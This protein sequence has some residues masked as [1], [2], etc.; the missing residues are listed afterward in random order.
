MEESTSPKIRTNLYFDKRTLTE[1]KKNCKREG[2]KMS[3]KIERFMQQYNLA[4]SNG[5]PQLRISA[6]AKPEEQ[7]PIRAMCNYIHGALSDGRVFCKPL[8]ESGLWIP[9]VRCYSCAKNKLR[10]Q[11]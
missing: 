7:Q 3:G 4:H 8:G 11:K 9:G 6:Y 1:F 10:N 2:V 5:N